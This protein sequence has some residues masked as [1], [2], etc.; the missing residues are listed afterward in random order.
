MQKHTIRK[1]S[2]LGLVL[3][4]ASAVAAAIIPSASAPSDNLFSLTIESRDDPSTAS[5]G[6]TEIVTNTP[7]ADESITGADSHATGSTSAVY[8]SDVNTTQ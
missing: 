6:P 4:A 7:C 5:C 8:P 3:V 2:L 1:F